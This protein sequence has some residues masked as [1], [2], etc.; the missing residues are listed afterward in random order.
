MVNKNTVVEE[1]KSII[2]YDTVKVEKIIPVYD[3]IRP[4]KL[5]HVENVKPIEQVVEEVKVGGDSLR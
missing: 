2:V 3:T 1:Q 4:K 5:K